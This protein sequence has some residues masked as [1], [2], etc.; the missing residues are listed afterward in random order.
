MYMHSF[1]WRAGICGGGKPYFCIARSPRCP[2]GYTWLATI[3]SS[4]FKITELSGNEVGSNIYSAEPSFN[5]RCS[6]DGTRLASTTTLEEK[7]AL[8]NWAFGS[9]FT[10]DK[11]V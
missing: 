8:L 3:A 7:T 4:C 2:A 1:K 10:S 5:K 9:E 6:Q 11:T